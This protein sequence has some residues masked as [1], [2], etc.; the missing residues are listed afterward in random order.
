V[1]DEILAGIEA[2]SEDIFPDAMSKQLYAQWKMDHKGIEHQ[3]AA[4]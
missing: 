4:M 2:G 3:F 1:A